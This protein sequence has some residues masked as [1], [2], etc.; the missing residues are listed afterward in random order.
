MLSN[1]PNSFCTARNA[2]A[3]W[4][5]ASI[6]S[7]LRTMPGF[8]SKL[9]CFLLPYLATAAGSKWSKALR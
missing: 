7:R 3:F 1:V 9:C 2:L 6:F 8:D 5:A 4:I